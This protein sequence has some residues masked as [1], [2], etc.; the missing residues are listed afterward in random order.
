VAF[1][2]PPE[3]QTFAALSGALAPLGYSVSQKARVLDCMR[4]AAE[5]PK[6]ARPV[7]STLADLIVPGLRAAAGPFGPTHPWL[8]PGDWS[9]AF[10]AHF[11]FVIHEGIVGEYPT[12]PLFAVEFD[13]AGAHAR[14][15]A[16]RRDLAKNRL[17][18]ASGLPLVRINDTFLYPRERLSLVEWLARLWAAYRAEM[19]DLIAERDATVEAMPEEQ[20][21][22]AGLFL[23]GEY[24]DLDVEFIFELEHP[25]PPAQEVAERLAFR[26]G[27]HWSEV[28][29]RP[30]V[31]L[32]Q[33][34]RVT[35]HFPPTLVL[36]DG[37]I[38]RWRC[39]LSLTGPAGHTTKLQGAADVPRGYPLDE[40]PVVDSWAALL[41]GRLP[42]LPA[43]P[44]TTAPSMLGKALCIHNTLIEVERYLQRNDRQ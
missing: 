22:E 6:A 13:S 4:A 23:L 42:Y 36:N 29:V 14:P 28:R 30:T 37:L 27:F 1:S 16:R 11:D 24:P 43:G 34:W 5:N 38:E 31:P 44:W 26:Y 15:A 3:V 8:R 17:C 41:A 35:R 40:G 25:F 19:P 9:Y 39:K 18:A 10:R 12:H 33:R 20:L 32:R 2:T 7:G 21:R